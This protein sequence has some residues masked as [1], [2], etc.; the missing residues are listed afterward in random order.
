MI[1]I[2]A[3]EWIEARGGSEN[4]LEAIAALYPDAD[5]ITPWNNAPHRFPHREVEELWLANSVLRNRKAFSVPF[6]TAAWRSALASDKTYDWIVASS[7]LF[8]HHI[9]ARGLSVSAP[10]LVYAYTPARYIW[11]PELDERGSGVSAKIASA[12]LRPIDR[13]RA[14]EAT[15][16]AGISKFVKERIQ[17]SW[18]R[19]AVVIYPPVE[20]TVIQAGGDWRTHLSDDEL[21]L[22]ESLPVDFALGASRFISYKRLD[23]VIEAGEAADMPVVLAGGG[24]DL[25]LLTAQAHAARVPVTIV[26]EPSTALLYA[27]YQRA[28]V[29]VFP[30]VEDFGIM[31]VEAMAL[32]TPVVANRIGGSAETVTEGVSGIHFDGFDGKEIGRAILAATDLDPNDSLVASRKFSRETFD[33]NFRT[34]M[35]ETL[36]S[37]GINH[38]GDVKV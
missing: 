37:H 35:S 9:K 16:I 23:L 3:H 24:P 8:S 19:E 36:K 17:A 31:P 18:D 25:D 2:I 13:R 27:I 38:P 21:V 7:H 1:G 10:K 4:V 30:P 33:T 32:G 22:L 28:T 15:S 26:N 29:F 11:N 34:W 20:T 5:L 14:A 6:L 12:F